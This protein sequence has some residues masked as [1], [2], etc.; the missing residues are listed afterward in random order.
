[1]H[2]RHRR[3]SPQI[4]WQAITLIESAHLLPEQMPL[5]NSRHCMCFEHERSS[6]R[7]RIAEQLR[8]SPSSAS[9]IFA[10][11]FCHADGHLRSWWEI[12]PEREQ[13]NHGLLLQNG[14][15]LWKSQ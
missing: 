11:A 4:C 14:I 7:E 8:K 15:N 2:H 1:M 10:R 3:F 13:R 6:R 12:F 5:R 9:S